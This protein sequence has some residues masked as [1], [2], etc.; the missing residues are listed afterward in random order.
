MTF[1]TAVVEVAAAPEE[2]RAQAAQVDLRMDRK[3]MWRVPAVRQVQKQEAALAEC[4]HRFI[5][6]K[7]VLAD[8][9]VR[10]AQLGV[11]ED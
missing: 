1:F 5:M 3:K 4:A 6:V 10:L 11:M 9:G 2:M 8:Q 7:A